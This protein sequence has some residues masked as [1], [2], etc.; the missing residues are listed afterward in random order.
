MTDIEGHLHL[1]ILEIMYNHHACRDEA[2]S[3]GL[4]THAR[5]EDD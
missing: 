1:E 5:S 2:E 3:F 4:L